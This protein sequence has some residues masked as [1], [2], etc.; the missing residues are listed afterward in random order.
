MVGRVPPF[1]CDYLVE[2]THDA[3]TC[4]PVEIPP[5][6]VGEFPVLL[7]VISVAIYRYDRTKSDLQ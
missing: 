4:V 2:F 6:R 1:V 3:V 5:C 7:I